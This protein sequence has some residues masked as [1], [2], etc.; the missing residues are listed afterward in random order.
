M[1]ATMTRSAS[2]RSLKATHDLGSSKSNQSLMVKIDWTTAPV[3]KMTANKDFKLE[4]ITMD[5]YR[6]E[7]VATPSVKVLAG[8]ELYFVKS[9]I[10]GFYYIARVS[11]H[12][13]CTC[14]MHNARHACKHQELVTQFA[15]QPR[16]RQV[17]VV[18]VDEWQA[19]LA[20]T[21]DVPNYTA[22]EWKAMLERNKA[23]Q[24]A[25]KAK[26]LAR[27]AAV[28]AQASAAA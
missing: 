21:K 25:E 24:E 10:D 15:A 18:A 19:E 13:S 7:I 2:R 9:S 3:V 23:W 14:P 27:L 1:T 20:E 11:A 26:D 28:K 22:E 17:I 4:A 8:T 16:I 12:V 5:T 6:R